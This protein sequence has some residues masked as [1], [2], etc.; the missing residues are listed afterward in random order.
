MSRLRKPPETLPGD[1][2]SLM[3]HTTFET[4][5]RSFKSKKIPQRLTFIDGTQ[6]TTNLVTLSHFQIYWCGKDPKR[7]VDKIKLVSKYV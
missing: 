3:K 4:L 7:E 5:D 1:A 2:L 6:F